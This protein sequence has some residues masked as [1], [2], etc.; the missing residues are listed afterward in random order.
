MEDMKLRNYRL[1]VLIPN[2]DK[3]NAYYCEI[4]WKII[5]LNTFLNKNYL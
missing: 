5:M 3:Q 1:L 2:E 4:K